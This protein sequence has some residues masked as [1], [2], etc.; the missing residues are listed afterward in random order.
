CARG[1]YYHGTAITM[2]WYRFDVW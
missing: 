2:G 1:D